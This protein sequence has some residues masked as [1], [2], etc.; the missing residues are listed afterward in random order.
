MQT[1]LINGLSQIQS[2]YDAFF[3]DLWGV[4]HNG[5]K[6]HS[7]AIEVLENINKLNKRFVLISNAPRPSQNV[8]NF[9]LKLEMK[10]ILLKNIFT[11]GE[12]ALKSLQKIHMEKIFSI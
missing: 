11:S 8:K 6:L 1:K 5:I 10:E 2:K 12:A 3:I 9:L 4:V 7:E